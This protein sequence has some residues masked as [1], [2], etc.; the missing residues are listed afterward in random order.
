[1]ATITLF[2][3]VPWSP[4]GRNVVRFANKTSQTNY[5]NSLMSEVQDPIDYEPRY[6]ASLNIRKSLMEAREYNYLSWEDETNG[7]L[8][9]F[10]EDYEYLNDK[11]TVRL[12][13]SE[14]VWQNNHLKMVVNPSMVHR[15]HMAQWEGS[16]PLLYPVDEGNARSFTHRTLLNIKNDG[17]LVYLIATSKN[18]ATPA[19]LP[20]ED[21]L[22]YFF[23]ASKMDGSSIV[24]DNGITMINP[25]APGFFYE[26]RAIREGVS[27]DA[28]QAIYVLPY[29][30]GA[31][32]NGGRIQFNMSGQWV[33]T[34]G[35]TPD[36]QIFKPNPSI[37]SWAG[38]FNLSVPKPSRGSASAA[39]SYQYIPQAYADN[40][41][42]VAITDQAGNM[43]ITIPKD[44]AWQT[45]RIKVNAEYF[46]LEPQLRLSLDFGDDWGSIA[47]GTRVAIPLTSIPV[48]QSNYM[49]YV[50][51][52]RSQD[53]RILENSIRANRN[54]NIVSLV[55]SGSSGAAFG[56]MYAE[57]F[58][59]SRRSPAM[60]GL[61]G[62]GMNVLSGVGSLIN[63][64]I[65][66]GNAR[67]E[68]ALN[69]QKIRNSVAP[70]I[71]GNNITP[72]M[73]EGIRVML[74]EA[75]SI[76][77][78]I[79]AKRYHAMGVI[80]DEVMDI[81]LRTRYYYDY[82]ETRDCSI[83]GPITSNARDYLSSLFNG[84]IT[85]WHG[86]TF[87]GFNYDLNNPEVEDG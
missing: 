84:G 33:T 85:I 12:I 49:N 9:Y 73:D 42:Y 72:V 87:R 36:Y 35:I 3:N 23:A 70:P 24:N 16:T 75:D 27:W 80:V 1:M 15:K 66:A 44:I 83:S 53:K 39:F 64:E 61:A 74:I 32:N 81:P 7:P 28:I 8:Y 62:A 46:S 82:I 21:G 5:F 20:A 54:Q 77:R 38:D 69:E 52:S 59:N 14:D 43:L 34:T 40:M 78:N 13:I 26:W 31:S 19:S 45:A 56:A 65:S 48:P 76:S 50:A 68:F 57:S 29:F 22:F 25:L 11:P 63:A 17:F 10:I 6:G 4:G 47:T 18:L 2:K 37:F 51:Q 55:T 58:N 30:G 41:S 86:E 71:N 79:V 60:A 67:E